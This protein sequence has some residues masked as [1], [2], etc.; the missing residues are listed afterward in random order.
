MSSVVKHVTLLQCVRRTTGLSRTCF[1][2][3][4][5]VYTP[6]VTQVMTF[7]TPEIP[8]DF[9]H[10]KLPERPKL[11][12]LERQPQAPRIRKEPKRLS[13]LRGPELIENDFIHKQYGIVAL[14]PGY[15]RW[16]HLEMARLTVN[17][18][19]NDQKMFAV[20]RIEGPTKPI[21]K[22][23]QGHRMGGGKEMGGKIPFEQIQH[24][25]E[26]VAGKLP[27]PARALTYSQLEELRH[28]QNVEG[29]N[30]NPW[31]FERIAKRNYL[32]IDKYLSP[33]DYL[34]YGKHR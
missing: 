30:S 17:R 19:M 24:I 23:G 3:N 15:L 34:W 21:T 11:K 9:D 20:W 14:G 13:D 5:K 8:E 29:E 7:R 2:L 16:G 33:Y 10:I 12:F 32:G 26:E 25:L 22:K 27:F 4:Y 6:M 28:S 31:T 18:K 1:G